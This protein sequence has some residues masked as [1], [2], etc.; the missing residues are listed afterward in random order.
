MRITIISSTNRA[1][2]MT[3]QVAKKYTEIIEKQGDTPLLLD[4]RVA[5]ENTPINQVYGKLENSFEQICKTHIEEVDRFVFIMPEYNGSFPGILKYFMDM[6]PPPFFKGKKAA[7]IGVS[8]GRAGN[9]RGMDQFSS[10]LNHLKV[11]VYHGKPKL[12]GIE[13]LVDAD[14]N[15][16]DDFTIKSL[17]EHAEDFKDF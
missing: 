1:N 8:S 2:S 16:Q 13:S 10:V 9:L 12:S 17:T 3:A 7:L 14:N 6:V 4:L 5:F 11:S 15:L